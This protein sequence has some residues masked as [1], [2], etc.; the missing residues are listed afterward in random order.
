[1]RQVS[2]DRDVVG[3]PSGEV[4]EHARR[5]LR[6]IALPPPRVIREQAE[7]AL[8]V[9]LAQPDAADAGGVE[10]GDVGEA[11]QRGDPRTM[12]AY[13]TR[14]PRGVLRG[15]SVRSANEERMSGSITARC[16]VAV[17]SAPGAP[18]PALFSQRSDERL[19]RTFTRQGAEAEILAVAG[20]ETA[21]RDAPLALLVRGDA[22]V[23]ERVAKALVASESELLLVANEDG[24]AQPAAAIVAGARTGAAAAWLA[25]GAAPA[26]VAQRSAAELVPAYTPE[27]RKLAP[28]FLRLA[29]SAN[30]GAIERAL[31]NAS[32]KGVTDVVTKY[33]WPPFAFRVVKACARFGVTPNA[34]TLVSW[35]L[36]I[37][38]TLAFARG[39]F[40]FGLAA[41]W[42]MTFLDTV[43][44]KLARV[45]QNSSPFGH[46]FDH[47]LDLSHPPVW[48]GAWALGLGVSLGSVAAAVVLGGYLVG[49]IVEGIFILVCGFE[50]HSWRRLDSFFRL[51]TAR[52]NP[53][54]V[55]L[56]A[57]TLAGAPGLGF[58]AVA[59]WTALSI[60]FH[61]VRLVHALALRLTGRALRPW[62][63]ELA[64]AGLAAAK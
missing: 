29:S 7:G 25:G 11:E 2:G 3:P 8:R 46:W 60:A 16:K 18:F 39:E 15:R 59:W 58:E 9:Q 17:I 49:R 64:L 50:T 42:A 27:L 36:V 21:L 20:A 61:V 54:L 45:T 6:P 24:R 55:L 4:V 44:G 5:D 47:G 19:A 28:P 48:W 41:A 43:D 26:G 32:Y 22:V 30:A 62:E 38:A 63:E 33:V 14:G 40:G 10:V 52:R 53:N 13:D 31:F 12:R 23:D 51:I 35:A 37:Y 34:V 56:S 1:M 57:C